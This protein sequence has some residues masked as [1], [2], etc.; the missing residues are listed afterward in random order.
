MAIEKSQ[1][2]MHMHVHTYT[3]YTYTCPARFYQRYQNSCTTK[4]R[5]C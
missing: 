2:H 3:L 5:R 4:H 1:T